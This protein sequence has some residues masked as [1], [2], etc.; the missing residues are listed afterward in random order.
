MLYYDRIY[1][2]EGII[3]NNTSELKECVISPD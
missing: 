3:V 2:Y 1:V